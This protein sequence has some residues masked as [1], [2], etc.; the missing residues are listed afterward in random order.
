MENKKITQITISEIIKKVCLKAYKLNDQFDDFYD[1][2]SQIYKSKE[3]QNLKPY[4]NGFEFDNDILYFNIDDLQFDYS[5]QDN[6]DWEED[7]DGGDE[8]YEVLVCHTYNKGKK[9]HLY[10]K[11]TITEEI[12][13]GWGLLFETLNIEDKE[14]KEGFDQASEEREEKQKEPKRKVYN[15]LKERDEDDDSVIFYK[16]SDDKDTTEETIKSLEGSKNYIYKL[17]LAICKEAF[18]LY[19]DI[20]D[21]YEDDFDD[22]DDPDDFEDDSREDAMSMTKFDLMEKNN[23]AYKALISFVTGVEYHNSRIY[24]NVENNHFDFYLKFTEGYKEAKGFYNLFY[25]TFHKNQHYC[26][27]YSIND[28]LA[29]GWLILID[30]LDDN[31]KEIKFLTE[32]ININDIITKI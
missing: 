20:I 26:I 14:G 8:C 11:Y 3:F 1:V 18:I 6:D 12:E 10:E 2:M 30:A 7:E 24:F 15:T 22:S 5:L 32:N 4:I 16:L 9:K 13:Q 31:A 28:K 23:K 27:E 21:N 25:H 19:T 29:V 17:I